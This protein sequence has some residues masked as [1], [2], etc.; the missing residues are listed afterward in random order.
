MKYL[1]SVLLTLFSYVG[2][3]GQTIE[4]YVL[5]RQ[6]GKGI[7]F[8][9]IVALNDRHVPIAFST[10]NDKGHFI[11]M[12]TATDS[13]LLRATCIGYK[14]AEKRTRTPAPNIRFLLNPDTRSIKEVNVKGRMPGMKVSGD[15]ID[16]NFRKYTDGTENVL[17]DILAKLPG[18]EMDEKGQVRANGKPVDKIT[19]N[20]QNF[21][22]SQNEQITKNMPV[23]FIDKIQLNNNYSEYSLLRG[24]NTKRS[25]VINVDVD[26]LHRGRVTGNVEGWGGYKKKYRTSVNLYS[27][28]TKMMWGLHAKQFNTG[29]EMMSLMDYIKTI[30]GIQSYAEHYDGEASII[31]GDF[32]TPPFM[33]SSTHTYKRANSVATANVAWNPNVKTKWNAYYIYNGEHSHGRSEIK[34]FKA[35]NNTTEHLQQTEKGRRQFHHAGITM[36]YQ[37]TTSSAFDLQSY[38]TLTPFTRKENENYTTWHTYEHRYDWANIVSYAKRWANTSLLTITV[39][40]FLTHEKETVDIPKDSLL[41]KAEGA[42][43]PQAIWQTQRQTTR[44]VNIGSSFVQ[45]MGKGWQIRLHSAWNWI[46]TSLRA[47]SNNALYRTKRQKGICRAYATG[48]SVD[49]TAGALTWQCGGDAIWTDA[50]SNDRDFCFRPQMKLEWNISPIHSLSATYSSEV[51]RDGDDYFSN[52]LSITDYRHITVYQGAGESLHLKDRIQVNYHYFDIVPD[53]SVIAYLGKTW[54]H[55]PFVPNYIS[56]EGVSYTTY[57]TSGKAQT[58]TYAYL[59]AKKGFA[60]RL[61]ATIKIQGQQSDFRQMYDGKES[62]NR[63]RVLNGQGVLSTKFHSIINMEIGCVADLKESRISW[64]GQHTRLTSYQLY[65]KPILARKGSWSITMPVSYIHDNASQSHSHYIDLSLHAKWTRNHLTLRLEGQNL[66]HTRH[67]NRIDLNTYEDYVETKTSYHLPGYLL[68]GIQ[69][70]I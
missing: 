17:A 36:S 28:G 52:S 59:Q 51:N 65:A 44:Q 30:G 15:T 60:C 11:I 7:S 69:W 12:V 21:F 58:L 26:S 18:L 9:S 57:A 39:N 47:N 42:S 63:W 34:R 8:A 3:Q 55:Q 32:A 33:D 29:E 23:D 70:Q 41:P 16:Y 56:Q 67:F 38:Y 40:Y 1:I 10:T 14:E 49:K 48:L 50:L 46:E 4:G 19:V 35:S 24:F 31:K 64:F 13:I 27:F 66:L 37:P 22:G 54:K 45:K 25:T 5:D 62:T 2:A 53:F 61:Q 20:G 6:S 43:Y 68:M